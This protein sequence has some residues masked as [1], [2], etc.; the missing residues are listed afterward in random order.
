MTY[1]I[2]VLGISGSLAAAFASARMA[3]AADRRPAA[4]FGLCGFVLSLLAYGGALQA[5][6]RFVHP[7]GAVAAFGPEAVFLIF[8][9]LAGLIA[10]AA[11]VGIVGAWIRL[12]RPAGEAASRFKT[13]GLAVL[14]SLAAV[15]LAAPF[16]IHNQIAIERSLDANEAEIQAF[17]TS[18]R[19]GL[20]KLT[21]LGALN[22][23]EIGDEAVTHYVGGPLY[24][25]GKQ[26]LAEYARAAMVYHTRVLGNAPAPVILRD[27]ATET[28]IGTFRTDGVFVIHI[29]SLPQATDASR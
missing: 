5:L 21:A 17:S 15:I 4:S 24:E 23:I 10:I 14:F 13:T 28:K 19:N 11:A 7:T 1:L 6:V 3:R 25:V 26:G 16:L 2:V 9:G 29:A 27:S 20:E 22:R 8:T 12:V 18:Y